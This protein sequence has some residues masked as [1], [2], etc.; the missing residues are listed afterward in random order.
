M[1]K[2]IENKAMKAKDVENKKLQTFRFTGEGR[3]A[4]IVIEAETQEKAIEQYND[5]MNQ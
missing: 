4:P 5:Y 1:Q 3:K 2:D